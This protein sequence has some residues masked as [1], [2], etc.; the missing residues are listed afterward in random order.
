MYAVITVNPATEAINAFRFSF[1]IFSVVLLALVVQDDL[2]TS[3]RW[4]SVGCLF[5][6]CCF[7]F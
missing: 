1:L 4:L 2:E 3:D 5:L 7:Y 6:S